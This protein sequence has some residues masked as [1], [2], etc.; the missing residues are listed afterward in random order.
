MKYSNF[1]E[2][3]REAA[4]R[5]AADRLHDHAHMERRQWCSDSNMIYYILPRINAFV[6]MLKLNKKLVEIPD[7]MLVILKCRPGGPPHNIFSLKVHHCSKQYLYCAHMKTSLNKYVAK[8]FFQWYPNH[9]CVLCGHIFI[10]VY[11]TCPPSPA[12]TLPAGTSTSPMRE[13]CVING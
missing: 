13:P 7:A 5:G 12:I 11:Q 6:K 4:R 3:Q 2:E 10:P 9:H 1:S 8:L